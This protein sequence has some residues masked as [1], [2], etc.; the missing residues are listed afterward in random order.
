MFVFRIQINH[1]MALITLN[2]Y[3]NSIIDFMSHK[4]AFDNFEECLFIQCFECMLLYWTR[5]PK[6][7]WRLNFWHLFAM[8]EIPDIDNNNWWEQI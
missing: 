4:N 2:G 5:Q 3:T 1:L 7:G 8:F 6:N